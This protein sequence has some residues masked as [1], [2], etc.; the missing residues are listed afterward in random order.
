MYSHCRGGHFG[1][2]YTNPKFFSKSEGVLYMLAY[3]VI[4]CKF[5]FPSYFDPIFINYDKWSLLEVEEKAFVIHSPVVSSVQPSCLLH[6]SRDRTPSRH[7]FSTVQDAFFYKAEIVI[8]SSYCSTS[9]DCDW[10][11]TTVAPRLIP[12]LGLLC[13]LSRCNA[14]HWCLSS[15]TLALRLNLFSAPSNS[16]DTS[17][18]RTCCE[19]HNSCC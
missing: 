11:F 2:F 3:N 10:F 8:D 1:P 17:Q 6:V 14:E 9:R 16:P 13:W 7:A 15:K 5:Y 4:N 12:Q 19:H 18:L